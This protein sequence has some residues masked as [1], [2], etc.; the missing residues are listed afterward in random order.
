[1]SEI[2][3]GSAGEDIKK[4]DV[5][6][7]D[8]VTGLWFRKGTTIAELIQSLKN[9]REVFRLSLENAPLGLINISFITNVLI[10]YVRDLKEAIDLLR[11]KARE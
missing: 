7:Q 5:I 4:G 8:P 10:E 1:M 3:E 6:E 9:L 2:A 11:K